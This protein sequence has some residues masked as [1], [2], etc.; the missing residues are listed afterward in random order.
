M[1]LQLQF[2]D[3]RVDLTLLSSHEDVQQNV[4]GF[5]YMSRRKVDVATVIRVRDCN[6]GANDGDN[7]VCKTVYVDDSRYENAVFASNVVE[8]YYIVA[9][10]RFVAQ[11]Y[12]YWRILL[13]LYGCYC[14]RAGEHRYCSRSPLIK[15]QATL[16]MFICI[17]SPSLV[18][19]SPVPV[20]CY[21]LAH[22]IDAPFAYELIAQHFS[23]PMGQYHFDAP[24]FFRLALTQMCN[25][26]LLALGVQ[27]FLYFF[28]VNRN[29]WSPGKGV[30]AFP[31]FSL[32][33]FACLTILTQL[34]SL[35][36]RDSRILSLIPL[37]AHA[38][39][40]GARYKFVPEHH[41]S[42]NMLMEGVILDLKYFSLLI[43]IAALLLGLLHIW[44]ETTGHYKHRHH[45]QASLLIA[46]SAVP[47]SAGSLWPA[48]A[49]SISW[50]NDVIS[51]QLPN[52]RPRSMT[53]K[54]MSRRQRARVR[55]SVE[56][57]K[58]QKSMTEWPTTPK[59][60]TKFLLQQMEHIHKRREQVDTITVLLN[61]VNMTDPWTYFRLRYLRRDIVCYFECVATRRIFM[62]P[63]SVARNVRD[64][65]LPW[66][67][68]VCLGTAFTCDLPWTVL[69]QCG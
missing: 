26:W 24:V 49:V 50:T 44:L 1:Q 53:G 25:V 29:N 47:Y 12:F 66:H 4:G 19:G 35:S 2:P 5:A 65:D 37:P 17:P 67:D 62:L 36:F 63:M 21:T 69:I 22:L 14:T 54:F 34:R 16:K 15:L 46:R 56:V 55:V 42:G 33:V 38:A 30:I 11:G 52:A 28:I 68:F 7:A 41:G 39:R 51:D 31:E 6:R 48:A 23:E 10:L 64:I 61:I 43:V 18:Y 59:Q 40:P 13:L 58:L 3:K 27:I 9:L 57:A 20:V 32:A 8:W 60:Q 45:E